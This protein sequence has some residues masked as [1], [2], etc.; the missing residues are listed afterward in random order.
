MNFYQGNSLIARVKSNKT[1]ND[2]NQKTLN[3]AKMIENDENTVR[4]IYGDI[5]CNLETLIYIKR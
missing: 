2:F 3:Y 1:D 4:F 5:D